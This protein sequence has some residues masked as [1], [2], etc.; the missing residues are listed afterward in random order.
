MGWWNL[1]GS[2]DEVMGDEPADAAVAALEPIG[3]RDPRPTLDELLDA[4]EAVLRTLDPSVMTGHLG[5]AHLIADTPRTP[6]V[7]AG[8]LVEAL[9]PG[10]LQIAGTYRRSLQRPPSL[11]ELLA[12]I[13]FE[14]GAAPRDYLRDFPAE[15]M[16]L[17]NRTSGEKT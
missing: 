1:P 7:A 15:T 13:S 16:G 14:L 8:E 6:G 5:D 4:L 10:V 11:R 2:K 9:R 12:A 17:L 3:A